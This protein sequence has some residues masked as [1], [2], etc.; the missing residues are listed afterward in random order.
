MA[1]RVG[2]DIRRS[3][4]YFE[5]PHLWLLGASM[6][7]A[8]GAFGLTVSFPAPGLGVVLGA[9]VLAEFGDDRTR[10][11]NARARRRYAGSA[12]ITRASGTR[13]VALARVAR[14]RRL[15]D[16]LYM[17]AFCALTN[18]A[19]AHAYYTARRARGHTH[20]QALRCSCQPAGRHPP[21]LSRTSLLLLR[22][23]GLAVPWSGRCL[24]S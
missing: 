6:I 13:L 10:Y 4:S 19:G 15:A 22:D 23:R 2:T 11:E 21:R 18:S 24:T 20:H 9:R 14:N 7:G 3:A 1:S 5:P 8:R 12:P 16:A 17:C